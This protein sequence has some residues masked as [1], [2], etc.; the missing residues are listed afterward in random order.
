[1]QPL[2]DRDEFICTQGTEISGH[3]IHMDCFKFPL[4]PLQTASWHWFNW[5][6]KRIIWSDTKIIISNVMVYESCFWG[7]IHLH[8]HRMN[9][10]M[11]GW[12]QGG[13][14]GWMNET[15]LNF[16][17]WLIHGVASFPL[18]KHR[19][20]QCPSESCP[21]SL[22]LL[23][24]LSLAKMKTSSVQIREVQSTVCCTWNLPRCI[25]Q[26]VYIYLTSFHQLFVLHRTP[27]A[28]L[29]AGLWFTGLCL[30]SVYVSAPLFS[31]FLFFFPVIFSCLS[32]IRKDFMVWV[33]QSLLTGNVW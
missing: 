12:M 2:Y 24:S 4:K 18:D 29:L 17:V 20:Q 23:P 10:W 1:M 16:R 15:K 33:L 30:L 5:V 8:W 3:I 7:F 28:V 25:L 26:Y 14:D 31:F 19:F 21:A 9:G 11:E 22:E 27:P 13:M 32:T 6:L